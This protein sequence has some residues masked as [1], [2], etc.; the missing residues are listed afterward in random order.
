MG[1]KDFKIVSSLGRGAY[2]EVFLVKHKENNK[3][4][5]L[6]RINKMFMKRVKPELMS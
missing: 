2:G 1:I 5:A 3:N 4:F 6:K